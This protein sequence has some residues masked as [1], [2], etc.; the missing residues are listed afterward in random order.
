MPDTKGKPVS[1]RNFIK[2]AAGAAAAGPFFVFAPN[3]FAGEKR[4]KIAKWAHFVPEFDDWFINV[5][6]AEW[7]KQNKTRVTVDVIPV[8][9][10][11]DH[12]F[13]EVSAGKGHDI[14]IFPWSPAEYHQHVIDHAAIYQ[15]VAI[16]Y[17]AIQQL[18]VR[19]TLNLT[20][21]KY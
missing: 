3:A 6:A 15:M 4:L 9:E 21:K 17:G 11:R 2:L 14:F 10:I 13:A 12:A 19:S 1:R 18:A 20:T 7:G 8:E 5:M 16:K